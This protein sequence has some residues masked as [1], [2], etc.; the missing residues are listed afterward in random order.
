MQ[1]H[2]TFLVVMDVY[3]NSKNKKMF[4]MDIN[5]FCPPTDPLLFVW[6][7]LHQ[8]DEVMRQQVGKEENKQ[9]EKEE[10]DEEH[11]VNGF[12]V[13]V[14]EDSLT[15]ENTGS[16]Q[17]RIVESEINVQ[18]NQMLVNHFPT[19][20]ADLDL[21]SAEAIEEFA[22]MAQK[23]E[24]MDGYDDEEEEEEEEDDDE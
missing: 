14:E 18:P 11:S 22:K 20:F 7:E 21:S 5:P 4:L 16:Y 2:C 6:E 23:L 19:D 15:F 10:Q 8:D 1:L 9:E 13:K 17:F 24:L 3:I 12:Q